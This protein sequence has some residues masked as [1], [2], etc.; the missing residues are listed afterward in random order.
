MTNDVVRAVVNDARNQDCVILDLDSIKRISV[1]FDD[2]FRPDCILSFRRDRTCSV[3][4][5]PSEF[6]EEITRQ[7]S[8]RQCQF[9]LQKNTLII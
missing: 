1:T 2:Y 5:E 9:F 7:F 6:L 8:R 4:Y 3:V